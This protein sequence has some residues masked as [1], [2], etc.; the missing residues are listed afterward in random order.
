MTSSV[1]GRV[2]ITGEDSRV[3]GPSPTCEVKQAAV[4]DLTSGAPAVRLMRAS[5]SGVQRV[6]TNGMHLIVAVPCRDL[7]SPGGPLHDETSWTTPS[8]LVWLTSPRVDSLHS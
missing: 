2:Q 7:V 6:R 1:E 4:A 8:P 5:G 3:I